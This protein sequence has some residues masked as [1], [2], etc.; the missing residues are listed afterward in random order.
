MCGY[1]GHGVR[2]GF[3]RTVAAILVSADIRLDRDVAV[4][5]ISSIRSMC[6]GGTTDSRGVP[7]R[8][9][10]AGIPFVL[11]TMKPRRW[12]LTRGALH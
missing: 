2:P 11:V 12:P 10:F 3:V 8:Q 1:P 5:R 7:A 4:L 6:P 9:A